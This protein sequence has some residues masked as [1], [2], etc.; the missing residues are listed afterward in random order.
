MGG[1]SEGD[2]R[3][4]DIVDLLT[5]IANERGKSV[6]QVAINWL[7]TRPTVSSVAIGART[8]EQLVDNIGAIEWRLSAEEVARLNAISATP[9]PFPYSHQRNFPELIRPLSDDVG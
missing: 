8:V 6:P 1:V 7:L 9:A 2:A 4:F 3:V 5:A